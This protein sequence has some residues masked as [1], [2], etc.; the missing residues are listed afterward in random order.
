M[1]PSTPEILLPPPLPPASGNEGDKDTQPNT[2]PAGDA[3]A[4]I[5]KEE[6]AAKLVCTTHQFGQILLEMKGN[7]REWKLGRDRGCDVWLG[8]SK[9][10]SKVH[11]ILWMNKND[12]TLLIK[13]V[14]TN[15]TLLNGIKLTKSQ[16][17]IVAHGD[18]ITVG[19]GVKEDVMKFGVFLPRSA[20]SPAAEEGIH[21]YYDLR[22]GILGQGA[23]ATVKRA[24]ERSTGDHYAVKIIEKRKVMTGTAVKR[25][26]DILK[27]IRHENIVGLKDYYEDDRSYYLVMELLEGG[28]LMDFVAN[29]GRIPEDAAI[30]IISQVLSAVA[31]MHGMNVSHRDIKPDNILIAND[32]PVIIKVS[33]FGLAKIA[34]SGSHLHTFCGTLAY[35]APEVLAR[36]QDPVNKS[37]FYS[38]KVDIWSIGCMAY[39][40]LTSY[41]PFPQTTQNELY[42]HLLHGTI[43]TRYLKEA[44]VSDAGVEFVKSLLTLDPSKRPSAAEA[45]ALQWV[46]NTPAAIKQRQQSQQQ[47][48]APIME[49][50]Q[51]D[52]AEGPPIETNENKSPVSSAFLTQAIIPTPLSH[53]KDDDSDKDDEDIENAILAQSQEIP[54]SNFN[55][56]QSASASKFI[57]LVRD[58]DTD[59]QD[60]ASPLGTWMVLQTLGKSIPQKDIY[61][62][63]PSTSFG[64]INNPMIDLAINESRMSKKHCQIYTEITENGHVAWLVDNS[65][66]G[67][68]INGAPIMSGNQ[69][70]LEEGDELY[71][72]WDKNVSTLLGFKIHFEDASK[73]YQLPKNQ[74][75]IVSS[76]TINRNALLSAIREVPE[77]DEVVTKRSGKRPLRVSITKKK[78]VNCSI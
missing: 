76:K 11:F 24:V 6:I 17:Y 74:A 20:D 31:Y 66:N 4:Y 52:V 69:A 53:E 51:L 58:I 55:K 54:K 67:C 1:Q 65:T 32:E 70:F 49:M 33:D 3:D 38:D 28:D 42:K 59:G 2:N 25:E 62:T 75:K 36:K 19:M 61:L 73:F 71:F 30:E 43:E 14:S 78:K 41:L 9:R 26:V 34:Q 23:F 72:F 7:M 16:G 56:I 35:L 13:D 50:S 57:S 63:Q 15:G 46:E 48:S 10:I 22:A 77:N 37:A 68:Y 47:P 8:H 39:V 5:E 12:S 18:E 64:R 44:G 27:K 29:N 40:I 60:E 21:K 45:L